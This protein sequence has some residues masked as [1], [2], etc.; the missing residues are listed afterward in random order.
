MKPDEFEDFVEKEAKKLNLD[1]FFY[2]PYD[3]NIETPLVIKQVAN[4]GAVAGVDMAG[5][6]N[7]FADIYKDILKDC[8]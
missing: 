1:N 2:N 8:S 4:K 3:T 7:F 6:K 5:A